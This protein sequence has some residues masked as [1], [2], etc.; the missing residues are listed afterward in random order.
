M[1]ISLEIPID[2]RT[3][4]FTLKGT[5]IDL[6]KRK[7]KTREECA[8]G[9]DAAWHPSI[10]CVCFKDPK[11]VL[12]RIIYEVRENYS[13]N[14]IRPRRLCLLRPCCAKTAP[15]QS[16]MTSATVTTVY[17]FWLVLSYP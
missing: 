1:F 3:F 16:A 13:E 6:K 14:T 2:S 8:H 17:R 11:A 4:D 10:I 15:S 12:E 7:K 5:V 9:V